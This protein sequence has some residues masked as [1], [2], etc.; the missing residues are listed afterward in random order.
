MEISSKATAFVSSES[1]DT[2]SL[3]IMD[4]TLFNQIVFYVLVDYKYIL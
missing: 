1:D 4:I 2:K 3:L